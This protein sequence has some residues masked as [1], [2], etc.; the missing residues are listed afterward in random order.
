MT[1]IAFKPLL[2]LFSSGSCRAG[3]NNSGHGMGTI[4]A[5]AEK[6]GTLGCD[7]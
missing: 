5:H 4:W 3:D 6:S 7:G 1:G 2:T